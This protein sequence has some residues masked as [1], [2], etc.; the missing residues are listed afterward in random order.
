MDAGAE[1]LG[2]AL[3]TQ[4]VVD[5]GDDGGAHEGQKQSDQDATDG[6][7]APAAR[8]E[9]AV[10]GGVVRG[11]A[12]GTCHPE[13]A[14]ELMAP[15]GQ[16]PAGHQRDEVPKTRGGETG[17]ERAELGAQS[18]R[19]TMKQHRAFLRR[20]GGG[21]TP[22]HRLEGLFLAALRTENRETPGGNGAATRAMPVGYSSSSRK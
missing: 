6:V 15:P 3:A 17:L 11:V 2:A 20:V 21:P 9:K 8:G 22:M 5:Q 18:R 7:E 13:D 1:D 19:N 14:R 10:Q 12:E 16:D 4:A